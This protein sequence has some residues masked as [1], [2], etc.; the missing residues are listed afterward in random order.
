MLQRRPVALCRALA[1][2]E[3]ADLELVTFSAGYETE[4]LIAAG[5]VARLRTSYAGLAFFGPAPLIRAGVEQGRLELCDETELTLA[6]GLAAAA[7]GTPWIPLARGVLGT[8]IPAVRDD[9]RELID[10]L[11]RPLLAVP[12]L[13]LDV[14]LLHVPYADRLGN[15]A[16]MSTPCL[17]RELAVAAGRTIVSA[18]TIVE[19]DEL[20]AL[21]GQADLLSFQVDAVVAAPGGGRPLA[22]HPHYSFSTADLCA[23]LDEHDALA[24]G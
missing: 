2:S 7:L 16:F 14:C 10:E 9:L 20:Q 17:D 12:A 11:G 8:D 5:R 4:L 15:A 1:E 19:P 6:A 24:P 3:V 21:A 23:Y 18:E 13:A 22:C